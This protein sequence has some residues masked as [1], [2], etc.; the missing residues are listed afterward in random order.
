MSDTEERREGYISKHRAMEVATE[1]GRGAAIELATRVFG[2]DI[3]D[4]EKLREVQNTLDWAKSKKENET[5][6]KRRAIFIGIGLIVVT[7]GNW[8]LDGMDY[9]ME[10]FKHG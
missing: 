9:I 6:N 4:P 10:I 2:V 7:I 5:A 3:G 1:A 8:V